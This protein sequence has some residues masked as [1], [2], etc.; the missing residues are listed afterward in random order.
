MCTLYS[1]YVLIQLTIIL[2]C[3]KTHNNN[4]EII[5][6]SDEQEQ[7]AINRDK[8]NLSDSYPTNRG[9]FSNIFYKLK[10]NI[11]KFGS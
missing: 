7:N 3:V 5:S 9:H 1:K 4:D 10:I 8:L 11:L 6:M 2:L